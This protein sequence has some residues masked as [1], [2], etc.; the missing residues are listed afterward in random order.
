MGSDVVGM[1]TVP[2]TIAAVHCGMKVLAFAAVTDMCLTDAL[3][4]AQIEH[5]LAAAS[6]AQPT[7]SDVISAMLPQL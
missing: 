3:A 1:S 2:E 6:A 7:T 4:V 5:I